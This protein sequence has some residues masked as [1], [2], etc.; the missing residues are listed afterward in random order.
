MIH[1]EDV[2]QQDFWPVIVI[3]QDQTDADIL[4]TLTKGFSEIKK[5]SNQK[6]IRK[7]DME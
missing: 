4:L 7:S 3:E 2:T 6:A 5:N 1:S